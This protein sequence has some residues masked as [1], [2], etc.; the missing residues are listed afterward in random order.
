MTPRMPMVVVESPYKGHGWWPLSA[1]RR[2]RNV[3]YARAC[4]ADC[5]RRGEAPWASHLLYTQPGVLRDDVP[6]ERAF[7]IHAGLEIGRRADKTVVYADLGMSAGMRA[8][9]DAAYAQGRPVE[10]RRLMGGWL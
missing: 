3:R 10:V 7:G 1:F 6:A 4:V 5:L 2:W 8:G 9:V